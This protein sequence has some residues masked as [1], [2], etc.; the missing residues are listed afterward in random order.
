MRGLTHPT[1]RRF[2]QGLGGAL[3][4]AGLP[5]PARAH[6]GPHEV[7]VRI[8][9]FVFDP[10][11]IEIRVGDSVTWINDDLAPHTATAKDGAWDTSALDRGG[12]GRITFETAGAH[13]YFCA[14]HPHMKGMVLVR[15][16]DGG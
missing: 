7:E 16:R 12:T 2:G 5:R 9:R 14:F 11:H 10:A 4:L 1:R 15:S 13:A 6:A 8:A 3:A